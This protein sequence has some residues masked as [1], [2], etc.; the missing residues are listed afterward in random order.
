MKTMLNLIRR[1]GLWLAIFALDIQID[2][3][4][5]AME[6]VR[7]PI[8]LSRMEIARHIA[9]TERTRLRGEYNATFPPGKRLIWKM[10]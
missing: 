7:C 6:L 8:T 3:T 5:Q 9:R 10:S 1:A 2:G 4:T